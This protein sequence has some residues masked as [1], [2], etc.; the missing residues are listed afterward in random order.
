MG[1][2]VKRGRLK[3]GQVMWGGIRTGGVG[4][5]QDRWGGEGRE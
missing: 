3:S 4:R 1:Y 2:V 5:D